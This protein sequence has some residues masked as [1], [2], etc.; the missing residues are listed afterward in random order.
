MI[1][2]K[3]KIMSCTRRI[4]YNH[5]AV[6]SQFSRT[7]QNRTKSRT[8]MKY[9][10]WHIKIYLYIF[11]CCIGHLGQ[12]KFNEFIEKKLLKIKSRFFIVC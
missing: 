10:G 6:Y 7:H 4:S 3:T 12:P 9:I 5:Y 8:D 2:F 11:K 1:K